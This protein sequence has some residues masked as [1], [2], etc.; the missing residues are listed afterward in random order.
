MFSYIR[1]LF[2]I[3]ALHVQL[4]VCAFSL[5]FFSCGIDI[6]TDVVMLDGDP[7]S[8]IMRDPQYYLDKKHEMDPLVF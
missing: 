5:F 8:V 3:K 2:H 6:V 1:I 7:Y 4:I